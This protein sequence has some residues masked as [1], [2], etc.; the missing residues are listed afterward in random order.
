M[1]AVAEVAVELALPEKR[2]REQHVGQVRA[3][4]EWVVC[5]QHVAGADVLTADALD[6]PLQLEGHRGDVYREARRVLRHY[7]ALCVH[8][9]ARQ[10][11]LFLPELRVCCAHRHQLHPVRDADERILDYGKGKGID[12]HGSSRRMFSC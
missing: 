9:A 11:A 7:L 6:Q 4:E 2:P 1:P 5:R 3:A 10:V 8:Y 12:A